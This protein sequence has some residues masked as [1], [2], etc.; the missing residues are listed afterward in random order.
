MEGRC[1]VAIAAG[2][3]GPAMN[4]AETDENRESRSAMSACAQQ[5]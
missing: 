5:R 4:R 2:A 3:M 1:M